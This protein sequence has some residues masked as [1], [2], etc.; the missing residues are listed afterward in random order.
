MASALSICLLNAGVCGTFYGL[1][2]ILAVYLSSN[3]HFSKDTAGA[4]TNAFLAINYS[5]SLLGGIIADGYLGQYG[6]LVLASIV[7]IFGSLTIISAELF[8]TYYVPLFVPLALTGIIVFFVGNGTG[9]PCLSTFLGDQFGKSEEDDKARTSWFSYYYLAIQFGSLITS[10]GIPFA[11]QYLMGPFRFSVFLMIV[12]P[13]FITLSIFVLASKNY[14]IKPP[15]GAVFYKF[16]K[17]LFMG[18]CSSNEYPNSKHWLDKVKRK[19]TSQEVEDAKA[20]LRVLVIF[21]PLPFFWAVFFQMYSIWVFQAQEMDTR[22]G[23]FVIPP[24]TTTA[25]NGILDILLIPIFESVIYPTLEK[26]F[27]FTNLRRIGAGHVFTMA[28][29]VVA[30]F[31]T[32]KISESPCQI[33]KQGM[34]ICP[35]GALH[36]VWILPQYILISCAEIL[37]SISGLDFAYAEAPPSMKGTITALFLVTT[38]IGNLFISALALINVEPYLKDFIFAGIIFVVLIFFTIVAVY[39]KYRADYEKEYNSGLYLEQENVP[40]I[41]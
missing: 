6:T 29:L 38:A 8:H 24:A 39:Y 23:S 11:L 4:L 32:L 41:Q 21:V 14:N 2:S 3:L 27:R 20:V 10:L 9:K 1:N 33:D 36:I 31:V 5:F 15:G 12:A 7:V 16:I 13:L 28:A 25:I 26:F 22:I 19:Y 34:P 37:L 17:I 30:G 35:D 18:C 40:S